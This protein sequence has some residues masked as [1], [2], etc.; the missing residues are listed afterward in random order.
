LKNRKP[1]LPGSLKGVNMKRCNK[2]ILGMAVAG[3]A[4][5]LSAAFAQ[6]FRTYHC[7]DSTQFIVGSYPVC[8]ENL[9]RVD[10]V[11]CVYR[12]PIGIYRMMESVRL[13]QWLH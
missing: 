9:I 13:G 12:N 7:A 4:A 10:D 8:T 3:M 1:L 6:T 5:F 2:I 11:T